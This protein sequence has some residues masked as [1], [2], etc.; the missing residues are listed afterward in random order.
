MVLKEASSGEET[1]L[2]KDGKEDD[3][4]RD[5]FYWSPDSKCFVAVHV[6]KGQEHKVYAVESSPRDQVQPKLSSFD[7]LKPGRLA[8]AT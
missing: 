2:T 7:Y 3:V 6:E 4:Y 8:G 5:R 1:V